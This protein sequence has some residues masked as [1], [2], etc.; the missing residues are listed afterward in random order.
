MTNGVFIQPD[1]G[2]AFQLGGG[3]VARVLVESGTAD[4]SVFEQT[5]RPDQRGVPLHRHMRDDE[6]FFV[7]EGEVELTAGGTTERIGSGGFAFVP[8]GSAHRFRN[9]GDAPARMLVIGSRNVQRLVEELA[10]LVNQDPPDPAAIGAAFRR[11]DSQ[12]VAQA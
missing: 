7:L 10:P 9:V 5:V 12:L 4:F 6:A 1:G 8:H 2:R 11:H 3:D